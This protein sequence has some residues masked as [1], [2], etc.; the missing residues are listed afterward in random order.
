[1]PKKHKK[2][3]VQAEGAFDS[4]AGLRRYFVWA[5]QFM[6]A[7]QQ[8]VVR[9][10]RSGETTLSGPMD[11][12]IFLMSHWYAALFVVVEGYHK[13]KLEDAS[14]D[15]LINSRNMGLLRDYRDGVYHFQPNCFDEL[16]LNFV[17]QQGS[18]EWVNALHAALGACLLREIEAREAATAAKSKAD[19]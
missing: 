19:A 11:Q 18:V 3:R 9:T 5:D 13:L 2:R 6:R 14:V 16:F 12:R 4:F 10:L 8:E 7:F 15:A 17:Q 1:M